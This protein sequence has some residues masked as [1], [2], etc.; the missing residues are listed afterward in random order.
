MQ[1]GG[2]AGLGALPLLGGDAASLLGAA[3][4]ESI[5]QQHR[6]PHDG[7]RVWGKTQRFHAPNIAF[8]SRRPH[9]RRPLCVCWGGSR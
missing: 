4:F 1:G 7:R 5:H 8:I 6:F 9:H 2:G 3:A